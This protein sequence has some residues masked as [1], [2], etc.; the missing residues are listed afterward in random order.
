MYLLFDIG[1]TKT[2]IAFSEDGETFGDLV[3]F[4]TERDFEVWLRTFHTEAKKLC[5]G[6]RLLTAAGGISVAAFDD[7]KNVLRRFHNIPEWEGVALRDR[8]QEI[9]GVPVFIENDTAIVG[10]GEVHAGAGKGYPI[11][12]YLTISTGVGG[13]R[14]VDGKITKRRIGYEP[15]HQ[16]IDMDHTLCP[17]CKSGTAED[18]LSGTATAR[19]FG[20]KAYEVEDPQVWEELSRW[21]AVLLNNTIVYWSP[22]VVILGGSMIV[23]DPAIPVDRIEAHLKDMLK[24]FPELPAVKK[25]ELGDIGGL[26]G[27]L[28][29]VKQCY[30]PHNS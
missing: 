23:G 21:T 14:F 3:K 1:G 2:R 8:L 27:A 13:T 25:A 9:F 24:I 15:G 10:L 11:A 30:N 17:E 19:R 22:D 16:I 29:Y 5:N 4:D 28:A 6:R 7:H 18:Y 20:V 12:A 26:H